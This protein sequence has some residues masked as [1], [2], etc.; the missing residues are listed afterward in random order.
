MRYRDIDALNWS[1]LK[2]M[3]E[4]PALYRWRQE[5][6]RPDTAAYLLGRA[7]HCAILE[8]DDLLD[9][10]VGRPEGLDLRT[11]DG[12]TWREDV[13]EREVLTA[14][15]WS[16]V[17]A[18]ALSVAAHGPASEV[19]SGTDREVAVTWVLD[20]VE[21]K[22]R[23]DALHADRLVDLKTTRGLGRFV[24]DS[25]SYLYHAQLAW[26]LDGAVAADALRPE[27]EVYIVAVETSEPYDCACY[28]VPGWVLEVGRG[29][30]QRCLAD[31][32]VCEHTG[33][34]PGRHP[35]VVDLDLPRWADP[36]ADDEGW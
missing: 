22:G 33:I 35:G 6:P 10:Y 8:P 1:S 28:R 30:Y 27:A 13:G 20:G 5:H 9:R 24:R 16:T 12:K 3:H 34:W 18:C 36:G 32:R 23:V 26:Y 21:C 14:A 4:S 7:V 19:L 15:Q 25:A 29:I 17:Q 11:K 31:L 2:A